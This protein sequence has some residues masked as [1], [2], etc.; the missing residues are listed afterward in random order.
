MRTK[1]ARI[2]IVDDEPAIRQFLRISL[3]SQ[4]FLI[5]EA[6]T[7]QQAIRTVDEAVGAEAID[8]VLLAGEVLRKGRAH[9]ACA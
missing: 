9:L 6:S 8:V 1:P 4:G 7:G 3:V 5:S 2:L